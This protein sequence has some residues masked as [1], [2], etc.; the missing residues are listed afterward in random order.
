MSS[1]GRAAVLVFG[2]WRF[3]LL[4]RTTQAVRR[5]RPRLAPI[6]LT[7]RVAYVTENVAIGWYAAIGYRRIRL[8]GGRAAHHAWTRWLTTSRQPLQSSAP[9]H[10]ELPGRCTTGR[11][12]HVRT[13]RRHADAT[14][15]SA[16]ARLRRTSSQRAVAPGARLAGSRAPAGSG[17]GPAEAAVRVVTSTCGRSC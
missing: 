16:F 1:R 8:R 2:V 13:T 3:R 5:H 4:S 14:L 17:A 10:H 6:D 15:R 9:Q 12:R 7:V 11:T